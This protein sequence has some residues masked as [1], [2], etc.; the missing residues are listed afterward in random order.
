MKSSRAVAL[1]ADPIGV[2]YIDRLLAWA[3]LIPA[4]AHDARA[5]VMIVRAL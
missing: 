1:P 4:L 2:T 3:K 5:L